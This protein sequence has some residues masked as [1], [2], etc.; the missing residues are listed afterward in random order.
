MKLQT[1]INNGYKL[2]AWALKRSRGERRVVV[3]LSKQTS[4]GERFYVAHSPQ[5]ETILSDVEFTAP[6]LL[7]Q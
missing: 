4:R 5:V 6:I 7:K 3:K 1:M 2:R